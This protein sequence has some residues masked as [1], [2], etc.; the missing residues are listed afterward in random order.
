MDRTKLL[1]LVEGGNAAHEDYYGL[2]YVRINS[3]AGGANRGTLVFDDSTV[4]GYPHVGRILT[5]VP[6]LEHHFEAPF[7]V[8]EKIDGYNTRIFRYRDDLYAATR[9]GYI[10]PF[11]TDRIADFINPELF[12]RHPDLILCAEVAGP[13]NPYNEESPP[14]IKKDIGFFVFDMM[15]KDDPRFL[16]AGEKYGLI[17]R[18]HLPA[19]PLFGRFEKGDTDAVRA[20]AERLHGEAREGIVMKEDSPRDHRAKYVTAGSSIDDIAITSP[21]LHD[22]EPDYYFNRIVQ[23]A[24]FVRENGIP[25]TSELYE[26][27]GRAFLEGQ[28]DAI[29]LFRKE[30]RVFREFHA[31]FRTRLA[32]ERLIE[33]LS[34][35]NPHGAIQSR[36][37]IESDGFWILKFV[38]N[39]TRT[40]GLLGYMV[41]GGLVFD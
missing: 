32:A 33:R 21:F 1:K 28:M 13:E 2:R 37:V 5:V 17:E 24:F 26:R 29:D 30:R 18:F 31:R 15:R 20:I 19:V 11:T 27:I 35:L 10:C 8:E 3:D 14:F 7:W 23:I 25:L 38:R 4:Y 9:G 36:G 41:G 39:Y 16:P 6:G 12:E 40:T 22:M 34:L